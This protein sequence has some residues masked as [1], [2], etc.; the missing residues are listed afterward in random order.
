MNKR[1][2]VKQSACTQRVTWRGVALSTVVGGLMLTAGCSSR[3]LTQPAPVED[4]SGVAR[5]SEVKPL[6]GS[7][8]T[9]KPGF[10]TVRPGDTLYRIVAL[11]VLRGESLSRTP[12]RSSILDTNAPTPALTTPSINWVVT[13]LAVQ[14]CHDLVL[15]E[16]TCNPNG[17]NA[18]NAATTNPMR[19]PRKCFRGSDRSEIHVTHMRCYEA[20]PAAPTLDALGI[21]AIGLYVTIDSLVFNPDESGPKTTSPSP[22]PSKPPNTSASKN[23]QP[24][25]NSSKPCS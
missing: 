12:V 22:S 3:R 21:I 16:S 24:S 9:G 17:P 23:K 10:Y 2:L 18:L 13:N 8:N 20:D 6:P 4:R 14:Y 5:S 11:V 15:H 25:A 1:E 7:E 19:F